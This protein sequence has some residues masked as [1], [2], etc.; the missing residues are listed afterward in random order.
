[1]IPRDYI[2]YNLDIF[3]EQCGAYIISAVYID[4]KYTDE[5]YMEAI[6]SRVSRGIGHY[7]ISKLVG[8]AVVGTTLHSFYR[9]TGWHGGPVS[10]NPNTNN[11]IQI[12][13]YNLYEVQANV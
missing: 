6:K 2:F 12:F 3:P 5:E 7:A 11:L 8:S 13:E 1:M 10:R 9:R 4:S